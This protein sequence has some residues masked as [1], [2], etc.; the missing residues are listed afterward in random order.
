MTSPARDSATQRPTVRTGLRRRIGL[1]AA[2]VLALANFGTSNAYASFSNGGGGTISCSSSY[3]YTWQSSTSIFV[4]GSESCN[5]AMTMINETTTLRRQ[6]GW[7]FWQWSDIDSC[8]AHTQP[9]VNAYCS[10]YMSTVQEYTHD[11]EIRVDVYENPP[12]GYSPTEAYGT[13]TSPH[14]K[15]N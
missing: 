4:S 14:F 7:F 5:A 9:G 11:H 3:A 12:L 15:Y 10:K 8:S 6:T 1:I 2:L 13:L